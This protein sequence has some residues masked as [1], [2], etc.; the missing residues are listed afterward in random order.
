M[1]ASTI[2]S[3]TERLHTLLARL[4]G[5]EKHGPSAHSTLDVLWVLYD[6]ILR[7]S[8][9]TVDSPDRDRFLLSKGHGPAAYYAV[10]AVKGFLAPDVLDD[11]GSWTSP[12]G[13]HPDRL[14]IPGAEIS[15]GSLGHGLPIAVGVALGLRA[16]GLTEPRVY[17]LIGD[18][19]LDEGSNHEAIAYAGATGLDNLTA[20]VIDNQSATHGWPGGIDTRFTA[21][22]WSSTTVDGRDHVAIAYGLRDHHSG[23]SHVVVAHTEAKG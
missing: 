5:D 7:V 18:A 23:H 13:H 4:T 17:V 12:L 21:N 9:G 8:P 11:M 10:L 20:I 15:S 2:E 16:Q 19:E 1:P 3:D 14:R 6:Q 22:G